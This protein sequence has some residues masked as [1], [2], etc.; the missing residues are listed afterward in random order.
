M[1]QK[2]YFKNSYKFISVFVTGSYFSLLTNIYL[3]ISASVTLLL[4]ITSQRVMFYISNVSVLFLDH[5]IFLDIHFHN[6]PPPGIFSGG[7]ALLC[8]KVPVYLLNQHISWNLLPQPSCPL[9]L[10]RWLCF[11]MFQMYQFI[12]LISVF[13]EI[14]FHNHPAHGIFSDGY[15]LLCSKC[16]SFLVWPAY[17]S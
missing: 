15:A 8:S 11:V 16:A 9:Y 12:W 17:I 1:W 4:L 14:C 6:R 10:L 7:Y 3:L 2:N 5:S 13:L